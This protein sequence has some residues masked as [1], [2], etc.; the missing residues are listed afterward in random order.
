MTW[1][2]STTS[3]PDKE[4][5]LKHAIEDAEKN[6]GENEIRDAWKNL[7]VFYGEIGDESR[8]LETFPKV[9][10]LTS[11]ALLKCDLLFSQALFA[12]KYD[13]FT[14][15]EKAVTRAVSFLEQG[16]LDFEHKNRL[17]IFRAVLLTKSRQISQAAQFF[18]DSVQSF[19]SNDIITFEEFIRYVILTS[20]LILSRPL[21]KSQVLDSPEVLSVVHHSTVAKSYHFLQCLY[22]TNYSE[23]LTSLSEVLS[24]LQT[25]DKFLSSHTNWLFRELRLVCL[26]QHLWAYVSVKLSSMADLF[27]VS[28]AILESDLRRFIVAGRLSCSIDEHAGIV[29]T[30]SANSRSDQGSVVRNIDGLLAKM[31]VLSR[32]LAVV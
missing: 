23:S 13:D 6:M 1:S 18:L 10:E 11:G 20:P 29:Y 3:S 9:Y 12:L 24:I 5:K 28:E 8:Y 16:S 21:L 15:A 4:N 26:K 30:D 31:Q 22:S 19:M 17:M 32:S 25:S 27:G 2:T 14:L 7:N